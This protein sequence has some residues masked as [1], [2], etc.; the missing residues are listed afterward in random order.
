MILVDTSIWVDHLRAGNPALEALL[1][2]GEVLVHPFVTG[3][4][5]LSNLRQRQLVLGILRELP[6]ASVATDLEVLL[7]LDRH[8]LFGCGIGYVDVHLLAAARLSETALLWT[9]DRRLRQVAA[10]LDIAPDLPA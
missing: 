6:Q 9:R 3:E 7:F 8:R 2:S 10:S 5:A 4:L 1:D